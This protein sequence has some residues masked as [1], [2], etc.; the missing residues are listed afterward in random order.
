MLSALF[1]QVNKCYLLVRSKRHHTA[2]K[3]VEDLLCGP[4]FNRLHKDVA[5]GRQDV[6]S[7]VIAIEGDLTLP[8]LGLAAEDLE[9]LQQEVGVILHCG[10]N[11][12]LDADVQMTL[13]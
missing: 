2:A 7:K 4:L 5:E 8:M 10:A 6:F 1:L 12:E 3:R 9:A 11:I 13:K